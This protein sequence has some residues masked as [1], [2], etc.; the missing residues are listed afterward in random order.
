MQIIAKRGDST[1]LLAENDQDPMQKGIIYDVITGETS[2][3]Y[4]VASFMAR[5]YW[6]PY[7]GDPDLVNEIMVK[8]KTPKAKFIR[9]VTPVIRDSDHDIDDS[10]KEA[11]CQKSTNSDQQLNISDLRRLLRQQKP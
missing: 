8:I 9:I 10:V 5:G 3:E 2:P 7:D 4:S 1:Y 11:E 6:E